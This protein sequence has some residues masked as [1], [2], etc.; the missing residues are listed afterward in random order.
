MY[1]KKLHL[2]KMINKKVK[3]HLSTPDQ[4]YEL[5]HKC[6]PSKIE[7][8]QFILEDELGEGK[9]KYL[10]VQEGLWAQQLDFTLRE[11]LELY[12]VASKT[13]N[14]FLVD[15]YLSQTE[16]VRSFESKTAKLSIENIN[17]MLTSATSCSKIS[18][19]AKK[20]VQIF[21]ILLSRD[22]LFNNVIPDNEELKDFFDTN[23]PIYFSENLDYKLKGLLKSIDFDKNNRL[24]SISN[25]IQI[26]EY[27]FNKFRY[28]ELTSA[29]KGIHPDDLN[30]LMKVRE[31][32]DTN[33]EKKILLTD[34]SEKAGMSLSKFKRL[35][36]QVLGTTPYKYHLQNKM[37]KAM[38]MLQQGKYSISETGFLMGY[39]NLSQ[40]SK[41]FKNHF[42]ILPSE[43]DL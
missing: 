18:I 36:K 5:L 43:L 28:R 35:F 24:T 4:W 41:A 27:L 12:R 23:N 25:T 22:W 6:L 21:N 1:L 32:L 11:N 17:L 10:K 29:A 14:Y 40:F 8:S 34:L 33:P 37:E 26:V 3:Y 13:N 15:F 31:I 16:I 7:G 9:L 38:E 19:P 2:T 30:N 20:Q 39:A 42:G